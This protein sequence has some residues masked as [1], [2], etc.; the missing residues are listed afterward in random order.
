MILLRERVG[1][2]TPGSSVDIALLPQSAGGHLL[3][4]QPHLEVLRTLGRAGVAEPLH[5]LHHGASDTGVLRECHGSDEAV[6]ETDEGLFEVERSVVPVEE[7]RNVLERDEEV[8][9]FPVLD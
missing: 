1:T 6:V 2:P 8:N 4:L 5:H 9:G 7:L 3:T